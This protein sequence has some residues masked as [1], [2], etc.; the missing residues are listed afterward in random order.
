[1][2]LEKQFKIASIILTKRVSIGASVPCHDD[3]VVMSSL[4]IMSCSHLFNLLITFS[5]QVALR[6]KK[7]CNG[8]HK[9]KNVSF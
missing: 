9:H 7:D 1:M 4:C 2:L 5:L 3:L 8:I 6:D